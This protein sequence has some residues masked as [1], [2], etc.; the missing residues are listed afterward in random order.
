MPLRATDEKHCVGADVAGVNV[1]SS[2][3]TILQRKL[4]IVCDK[5]IVHFRFSNIEMRHTL[6][7]VS[8]SKTLKFCLVQAEEKPAYIL[9]LEGESLGH[10]HL[11]Y[12]VGGHRS[13]F[14]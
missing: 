12:K 14:F 4:Q 7:V 2:L 8:H 1:S 9:S 11:Y 10:R 6:L 13:L 5:V 3:Q